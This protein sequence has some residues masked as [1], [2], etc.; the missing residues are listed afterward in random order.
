M[1]QAHM[2]CVHKMKSTKNQRSVQAKQKSAIEFGITF[3]MATTD[4]TSSLLLPES[5]EETSWIAVQVWQSIVPSK[6]DLLD[7]L[8][9]RQ[10]LAVDN[11]TE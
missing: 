11:D 3:L 8:A 2:L 7:I 9:S 4:F 5:A 10:R 6:E 1:F